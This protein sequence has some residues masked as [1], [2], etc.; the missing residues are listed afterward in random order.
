MSKRPH[1][2]FPSA[3]RP[4]GND[5]ED[6]PDWMRELVD[7]SGVY[8]IRVPDF[9]ERRVVYVGES[10]TGRLAKTIVRHFQAWRRAGDPPYLLKGS[11]A[12]PGRTYSRSDSEVCFKICPASQA[13]AIALQDEWIKKLHPRDNILGANEEEVPF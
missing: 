3:W 1:R 11:N 4:V 8:A 2:G 13:I 7:A 9:T 6:Y 5:G 10:H 12:D